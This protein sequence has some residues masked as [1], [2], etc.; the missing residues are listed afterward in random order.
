MTDAKK[1]GGMCF[2]RVYIKY[3]RAG[4]ALFHQSP[5]SLLKKKKSR[6]F[7][8]LI[9]KFFSDEKF[10]IFSFHSSFTFLFS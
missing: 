4:G 8:S 5:H 10:Y 6:L 7:F 9:S 1:G 2:E 3:L